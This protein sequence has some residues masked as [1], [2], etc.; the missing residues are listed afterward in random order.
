MIG[1]VENMLLSFV[2]IVM[3]EVEMR[4]RCAGG[5]YMLTVIEKVLYIRYRGVMIGFDAYA[6]QW[7]MVPSSFFAGARVGLTSW[8]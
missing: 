2:H 6:D 3:M 4:R 5:C 8:G 1:A 7:T